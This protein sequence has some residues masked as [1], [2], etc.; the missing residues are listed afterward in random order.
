MRLR[1][2]GKNTQKNQKGPNDLD[3]HDGVVTHLQPDILER[4][5]KQASGSIL[6]TK[7]VEVMV[8][9]LSYFRS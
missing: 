6:S 2:R 1:R 3:N 9:Q 5:V 8:F 4:E 7:L